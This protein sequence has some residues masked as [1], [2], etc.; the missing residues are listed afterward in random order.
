MNDKKYWIDNNPKDF[1]YTEVRNII[2][3]EQSYSDGFI[4]ANSVYSYYCRKIHAESTTGSFAI[5]NG[6][7]N[8]THGVRLSI[9]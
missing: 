9:P 6:T 4:D 1:S 8:C 5:R 3:Y 2:D 7:K